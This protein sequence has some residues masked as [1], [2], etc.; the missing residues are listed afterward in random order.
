M[1]TETDLG[2]FFTLEPASC[3]TTMARVREFDS[4]VLVHPS[5]RQAVMHQTD[6]SST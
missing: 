1:L 4:L 5:R 2:I 3:I 6:E